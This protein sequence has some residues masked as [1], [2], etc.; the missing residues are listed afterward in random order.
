MVKL[1]IK[2]EQIKRRF[3]RWVTTGGRCCQSTAD[4]IEKAI[5]LYEDF[6]KQ[7]DFT[8]FNPTK[9]IAFREWLKKRECRGK[10]ISLATYHTYL[11]HLQKFFS[12]LSLQ[13]G[14]K[15]KI[16]PYIVDYLRIS[17]KDERIATQYT[18][19]N[20]PPLEYVIKLAGSIEINSEIDLRDRA[21]IAFTLLSGMRDKAIA[22]LPLGCFDEATLLIDQNPRKGVETK[23]SKHIPTTLLKFDDK[24]LGYLIE[25]IR[26]LK[27]KGFGSQD[28]FFPRSKQGQ[29]KD[30]LSFE[31]ATEIEPVFWQGAGRIREIFKSRSKE[32]GLP[33]YPPHTFRHLA[34]D[35]AFKHW[36]TGEQLKAISQN[37]GHERI[38][39][40]LSYANYPQDRLSDILKDME[41]SGE[42][43]KPL[44]EQVKELIKRLD[45]KLD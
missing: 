28:P 43:E 38:A 11:R 7:A 17:E 25:W 30:N 35:L 44:N 34:F 12:W 36:K 45:K 39:T 27:N 8:T 5:L 20:F 37:F 19:R 9:A 40:S 29:G 16:T 3:L 18:P 1:N 13:A 33:Y 2:N 31:Q 26:H 15:S 4:N 42:P 14:Y 24:L 22:T 21:L 6:T 23:F 32:A 41:F 10:S